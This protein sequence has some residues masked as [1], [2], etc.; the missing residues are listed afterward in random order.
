MYTYN[1]KLFEK[2]ARSVFRYELIKKMVL[3]VVPD[4]HPTPPYKN[5]QEPFDEVQWL[6]STLFART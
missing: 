1:R 6:Y 2:Q 5:K 3:D 4:S